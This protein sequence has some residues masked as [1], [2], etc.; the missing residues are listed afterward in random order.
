LYTGRGLFLSKEA[1][2]RY[3]LALSRLKVPK[4][5]LKGGSKR[6]LLARAL[7]DVAPEP[8]F[9]GSASSIP[10]LSPQLALAL[11]KFDDWSWVDRELRLMEEAG[12]RLITLHDADY[13]LC[14]KEIPDP[15]FFLYAK[16]PL[17]LSDYKE[18]LAIVGTRQPTHYGKRFAESLA[19]DMASLGALIVSGMA[20]G[21]DMAAHK[22]A[23]GAGG[24]TV[25]VLGTG[26]D[27]CYPPEAV[28]LYAE[29]KEKGLLVS[30]FPMGTGPMSYNFPR[31]N[32][33][34]SGLSRGVLVAEAPLRSGAM[35]TAGIA[36]EHNRD[37][38]ALPGPVSSYKSRGP[39]S[40]IKAGAQLVEG[41]GDILASWGLEPGFARP[42]EREKE[43][44]PEG[45]AEGNEATIFK[46]LEEGPLSIDAI[47]S[48][49]GLKVQEL[50]GL[51][52]EMEL[53]GLVCQGPGKIFTRRF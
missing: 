5:V 10:E 28:G 3:W 43:R 44:G 33:I 24:A 25:A 48:T 39:N 46:T 19:G 29:I 50:G 52:L 49:C 14:L 40:L 35:M 7:L 18:A 32:R 22:G 34:I 41:A 2:I 17:R 11:K 23:L 53:K 36:L 15:P 42:L 21:C 27:C 51:L 12:A 37:V 8:L 30:E 9:K 38:F 16:G 45:P 26:V 31:R 4:G 6:S 47:A 20:R 13:P 1:L